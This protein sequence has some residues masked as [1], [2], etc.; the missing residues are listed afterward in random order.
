MFASGRAPD[1]IA[2]PSRVVRIPRDTAVRSRDPRSL[3]EPQPNPSTRQSNGNVIASPATELSARSIVTPLRPV[4]CKCHP[5]EPDPHPS[6]PT[7]GPRP[8]RSGVICSRYPPRQHRA[9]P[10][11]TRP[12]PRLMPLLTEIG[13]FTLAVLAGVIVSLVTL[14]AGQTPTHQTAEAGFEARRRRKVLAAIGRELRWNRGATQGKLDAPNAHAGRR[15]DY[16]RL[17]AHAG[18]LATIAPQSVA[19]VYEH[20]GMVGRAQE[21]IRALGPSGAHTDPRVRD[22]WT[23]V[24]PES[25]VAVSNSPTE[26]LDSLGL[27]VGTEDRTMDGHDAMPAWA[28]GLPRRN[29][30][31]RVPVHWFDNPDDANDQSSDRVPSLQPGVFLASL[32]NRP[33]PEVRELQGPQSSRQPRHKSR[34]PTCP[35]SITV[36]ILEV[37]PK[38]R[39]ADHFFFYFQS[40]IECVAE[41]TGFEPATPGVTGRYSNQLNYRSFL[42][43]V[44]PI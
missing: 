1:T 36:M 20:Y 12:L 5:A 6:S 25:S 24:C 17:R 35:R 9:S 39:A 3:M 32:D 18:E 34:L 11:A 40:F 38:H 30:C 7:T 27:P 42:E 4:K 14:R 21:G 44:R 2:M 16:R 41:R 13:A 43:R 15:A 29:R 8:L 26:A 28:P 19:A 31:R 10:P 23:R 33:H 22:D 37:M